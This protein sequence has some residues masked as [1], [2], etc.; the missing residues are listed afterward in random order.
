MEPKIDL[1]AEEQKIRELI[2]GAEEAEQKNTL[3]A[4]M[5]MYAEDAVF[6]ETGMPEL[7]GK[8]AIRGAFAQFIPKMISHKDTVR[9]IVVSA[10]GDLAYSIGSSWTLLEKEG[11]E[12][13][14]ELKYRW[15]LALKKI[16]GE[17]KCVAHSGN[18]EEPT[19]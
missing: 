7:Q 5:N 14:I 6:Q 18:Y 10:S 3:E 13:G 1:K 11:V 4:F 2:L 19:Q 16:G 17:W 15:L 9:N 8:E 12:G